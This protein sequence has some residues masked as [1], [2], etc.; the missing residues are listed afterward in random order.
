MP[1]PVLKMLTVGLLPSPL[2]ILWYRL[3][4]AKIGKRVK[5]GLLSVIEAE[6]I[7]IGDDTRIGLL[8]F[9][10]L[11]KNL[12]L[13]ARVRIQ[14]MVAADTGSL[15]VGDD[16]TIME[17]VII[18]GMLTPRSSISIGKRVKIFP[19]AFLNPTE[20]IVIEDD[21]GIG[22]ASYI[23]T[24]GSWQN[25]LDGFQASFAPVHIKKGAWLPWRVFVLPGVTIGEQAMIGPGAL[26]T[27]SVPDR[28]AASGVPAE[29]R[30]LQGRHIRRLTPAFQEKLVRKILDDYVEYQQYVGQSCEKVGDDPDCVEIVHG[31]DKIVFSR[32]ADTAK[33]EQAKFFISLLEIPQD[34]IRQLENEGVIWFDLL[35]K[36]ASLDRGHIAAEL[37]NYFSRHGIRFELLGPAVPR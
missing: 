35:G 32:A 30:D 34:K 17:Q 1:I 26:V 18:G 4:G 12:R 36:R 11:R 6:N 19:H 10:L 15:S 33:L 23:F 9:L 29:V 28:G 37:R 20:E 5:I 8:S 24:H 25:V 14:S 16:S 7:V 13:G 3:R 2:K 31:K 21:V 27:R 22:G